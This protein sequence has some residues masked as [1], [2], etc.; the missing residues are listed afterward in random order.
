MAHDIGDA[1]AQHV[2]E[3]LDDD[4]GATQFRELRDMIAGSVW[5]FAVLSCEKPPPTETWQ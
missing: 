5:L 1:A 4:R 2:V 3:Q